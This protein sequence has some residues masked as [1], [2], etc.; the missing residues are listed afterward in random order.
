MLQGGNMGSLV[1]DSYGWTTTERGLG[2]R[3]F[4]EEWGT[5]S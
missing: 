3:G 2:G 4:E 1:M 5:L